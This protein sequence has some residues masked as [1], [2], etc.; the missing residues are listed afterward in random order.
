MTAS[1][2]FLSRLS[3]AD[4]A[5]V[6]ERWSERSYRHSELIVAHGDSG[7]NVFFLLEG[8]ARVTLFSQDG[9]EIA[10]RDIEPGEI[11]GELAGIDGKARSA[12]VIAVAADPRVAAAGDCIPGLVGQPPDLRMDAA[13]TFVDPAA[14]DDRPGF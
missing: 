2:A 5:A 14:A 7:R 3:D 8:R 12:S 11:F 13:R 1:P 10:Y 4:R 6:A 9:K